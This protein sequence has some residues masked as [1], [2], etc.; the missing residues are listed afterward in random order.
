MKHE[1]FNEKRQRREYEGMSIGIL[2]FNT[3]PTPKHLAAQK[4]RT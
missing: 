4:L 3:L 2:Q 1:K